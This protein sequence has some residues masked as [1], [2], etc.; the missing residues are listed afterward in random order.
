MRRR[1]GS[2][3]PAMKMP[4]ISDGTPGGAAVGAGSAQ[5][6]RAPAFD[7]GPLPGAGQAVAA[8]GHRL[9]ARQRPGHAPGSRP[10][11][12]GRDA[13]IL[14][15]NLLGRWVR[16]GAGAGTEAGSVL[17]GHADP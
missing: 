13:R 7:A 1:P 10:A 17:L 5:S 3:W 6:D 11:G 12:G 14:T 15:R 4:A 16:P 2:R 9:R 8:T